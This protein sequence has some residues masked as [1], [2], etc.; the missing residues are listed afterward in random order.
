MD[1]FPGSTPTH[2]RAKLTMSPGEIHCFLDLPEGLH[3]VG[4]HSTFDP[5]GFVLVV[6]GEA[7]EPTPVD[8]ELPLLPG[9]FSHEVAHGPDGR[10]WMRSRFRRT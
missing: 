8:Q 4:V 9:F 1:G 10:R 5:A 2:Q 7:L 6:E 3:I